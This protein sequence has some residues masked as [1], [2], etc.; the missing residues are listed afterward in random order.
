M[1]K[2][3]LLKYSLIKVI[4]NKKSL[5]FISIVIISTILILATLVI[6]SNIISF[7]NASINQNIGFRT[8]S[9]SV[10]VDSKD[11]GKEEITQVDHVL[12][13]YN[14][15]YD[16]VLVDSDFSTDNLNGK[17]DLLYGSEYTLPQI[18]SGDTFNSNEKGVAIC[19]VSFYPDDS[20]YTMQMNQDYLI[21]GYEILNKTFNIKYYS[22]EYDGFKVNKKE[23]FTKEL[24]IIGLYDNTL[25]INLNNQCYISIEDMKDILDIA[26]IEGV[27]ESSYHAFYVVVDKVTN[28]NKVV[29]ELNTLGFYNIDMKNSIDTEMVGIIQVSCFIILFIVVT[30]IIMISSFYIKKRIVNERKIIGSLR[31]CGFNKKT[32]KNIYLTEIFLTTCIAYLIGCILFIF[33]FYLLKENILNVF[34]SIG[35]VFTINIPNFILSFIAVNIMPLIFSIFTILKTINKEIVILVGNEE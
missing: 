28:I 31:T 6:N 26:I 12:E 22:Y 2:K 27:N 33:A 3:D 23:E 18:I 24:K 7:V 5:C 32:I 21:N 1:T 35:V 4:R 15:F 17:V 11:L 19:P 14:S 34:E 30:S 8:L 16:S 25:N 9:V 29:E 20:I 13:V 10:K